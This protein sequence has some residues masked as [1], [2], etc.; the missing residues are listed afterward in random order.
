MSTRTSVKSHAPGYARRRVTAGRQVAFRRATA[1][2][3][4]QRVAA[5]RAVPTGELK[6]HDI[7]VDDAVVSASGTIQNSGSINLIAQGVT[8]SERIGRKCVI[9]SIN[10]RM[11]LDN[12]TFDA[13][14][15]P[16]SGETIRTIMYLDRQANGATATVTN[17]LEVANLHSFNNLSEKNRFLILFDKFIDLNYGAMASDGAGVVSGSEVVVSDSFFKKCNIPLE[18]SAGT[19]ALTEIR[20]NNIGV[21]SISRNGQGGFNSKVR[22]RFTDN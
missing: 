16:N 5:A 14:G 17:I 9:K 2:M 1:R 6:F 13:Q 22:L 8:E 4:T 10:W 7:D 20:S 18:F 15:V 21:L 3:V 11:T 12:P 19:G